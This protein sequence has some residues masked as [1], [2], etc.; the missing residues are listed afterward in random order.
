MTVALACGQ[1]CG[2]DLHF[3]GFLNLFDGDKHK[4]HWSRQSD[5]CI[6]VLKAMANLQNLSLLFLNESLSKYNKW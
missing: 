2:L 3:P 6:T 4:K 5:A 1:P